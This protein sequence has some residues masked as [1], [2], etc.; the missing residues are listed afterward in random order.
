MLQTIIQ[1]HKIVLTIIYTLNSKPYPPR[2][3]N[4]P[5]LYPKYPL[6][7]TLR[8]L[9]KGHWGVLVLPLIL[10]SALGKLPNG[11]TGSRLAPD[12]VLC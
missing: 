5:L 12:L 10:H 6:L 2:P 1:S 8:A 7:R 3:R 4:Y 11:C 9:L